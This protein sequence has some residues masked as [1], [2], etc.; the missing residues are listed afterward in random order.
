MKLGQKIHPNNILDAFENDAGW[1]KN[2][3]AR[4]RGIFP[5]MAILKPCQHSIGHIY[6]PIFMKLGQ[7][8]CPND[9]LDEFENGYVCMK[10]MAAK[11]RGIFL[12]WLYTC[13]AIVKSC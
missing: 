10:N 12:I 5:Y 13:K 4:G 8:I 11:G 6:F 7:K 9:I 2:M 3:A 1:L